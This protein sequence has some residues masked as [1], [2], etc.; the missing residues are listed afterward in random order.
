MGVVSKTTK[1]KIVTEDFRSNEYPYGDFESPYDYNKDRII[2]KFGQPN[3]YTG[4]ADWGGLDVWTVN[5]DDYQGTFIVIDDNDNV[6]LI[7][8]KVG[9]NQQYEDS[10]IAKASDHHELTELLNQ[11][12]KMK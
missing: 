9:S 12:L 4:S 11:A 5:G 7:T 6:L 2:Q 8:R 1:K 10:I 3:Q